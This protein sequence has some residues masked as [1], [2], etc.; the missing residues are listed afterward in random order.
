V[1]Q[2][3][4]CVSGSHWFRSSSI[5]MTTHLQLYRSI[6]LPFLARHLIGLGPLGDVSHS[7]FAPLRDTTGQFMRHCRDRLDQLSHAAMRRQRFARTLEA[8]NGHNACAARWMPRCV[9]L[10]CASPPNLS[11]WLPSRTNCRNDSRSTVAE[12]QT[13]S[14]CP[15]SASPAF[16]APEGASLAVLSCRRSSST[17]SQSCIWV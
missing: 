17:R 5:R 16:P 11:G 2:Q 15:C 3:Y 14:R 6:G 10:K 1:H 4:S 12:R 13:S 9:A 7:V 8:L